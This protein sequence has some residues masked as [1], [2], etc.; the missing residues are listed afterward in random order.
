M[1]DAPNPLLQQA[2]RIP[3]HRIRA[4]H[5]EPGVRA[6]LEE[7]R[8]EV[9]AIASSEGAPTWANTM[10]ALDDLTERLSRR[11]TP[12][13]HLVSVAESPELREAYNAVLPAISEFWSG[14]PLDEGLWQRV[15]DYAATESAAGLTGVHRRHLHKT[16]QEFRRA[17]AELP[18]E[19][20]GRLKEL[21][22]EL[23]G[24]H[25]DWQIQVRPDRAVVRHIDPGG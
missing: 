15:R 10:A 3:F 9:Q 8:A 6:A 23:A 25:F 24:G 7:A 14:L 4:E 22:V 2:S 20:K 12:A 13:S 1:H 19:P 5:V 18:T 11:V 16:L 21:R 17:G